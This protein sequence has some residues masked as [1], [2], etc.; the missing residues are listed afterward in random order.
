ML[1]VQ[2]EI[3]VVQQTHTRVDN[4]A[5]YQANKSILILL[6]YINDLYR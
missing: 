5:E 1:I 4:L 6:I 2:T 3:G